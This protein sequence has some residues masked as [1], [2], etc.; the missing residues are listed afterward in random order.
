MNNT[1]FFDSLQE[2]FTVSL[3]TVEYYAAHMV[4]GLD[5][6]SSLKI[7]DNTLA[8]TCGVNNPAQEDYEYLIEKLTILKN[9]I[10]KAPINQTPSK[11]T[12]GSSFNEYLNNLDIIGLLG[13][14]THYNME[15]M[16]YLYC[17]C[18]FEHV[19]SLIKTYS[20]GLLETNLIAMESCLYGSGNNYKDD[21]G[22][23]SNVIDANSKQGLAMLSQYGVGTVTTEMLESLGVVL[24]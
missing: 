13:R 6:N 17:Q 23:D 19:Q 21:Q 11:K 2:R 20:Q 1:I 10:E 12:F 5:D 7:L 8:L 9:T 15:N 22:S 16:R 3:L 14:M 18:H 4:V 24:E